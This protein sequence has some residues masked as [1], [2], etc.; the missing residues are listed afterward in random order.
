[1]C[2]LIKLDGI[3]KYYGDNLVLNDIQLAIKSGVNVIL[4]PNGAGKSTL[5]SIIS[6]LTKPSGG[7]VLIDGFSPFK[8]PWLALKLISVIPEKPVFF[9]IRL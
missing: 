6:G 7:Q 8:V 2:K 4:G 9:G 3:T 5:I 1:M